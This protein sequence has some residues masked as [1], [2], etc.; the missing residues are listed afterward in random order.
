MTKLFLPEQ[1]LIN[2]L[3]KGFFRKRMLGK[4]LNPK[5]ELLRALLMAT[6]LSKQE[7]K[8][9]LTKVIDFYNKKIETLK[10][11]G[12]KKPVSTAINDEKL[13]KSR[14][15]NLVVW[16]EA[17]QM[18]ADYIGQKYIWLPS[19]SK[20]PRPEHQLKYGK[21]YTVGDGVFPG[22]EYGCKCGALI[23]TE[24]EN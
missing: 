7:I 9:S 11:D 6:T 20:E 3:P 21:V 4:K 18:K 13:L 16:N 15:E 17:Q 8:Q 14:V 22:E 5:K 2:V 19:S 12:I 24:D 1:F 10:E 23:L